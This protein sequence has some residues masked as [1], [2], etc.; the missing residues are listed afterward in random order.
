MLEIQA[1][2]PVAQLPRPFEAEG[3]TLFNSVYG[4]STSKKVKRY[5]IVAAVDG[6]ALNLYNVSVGP[7]AQTRLLKDSSSFQVQS[8]RLITSYPVPP[9]STFPCPPC[10][11]RLKNVGKSPSVRY[12]YCVI[13]RPEAQLQCFSETDGPHGSSAVTTSVFSL[14]DTQSPV[15]FLETIPLPQKSG[16]P[17]SCDI[18]VVHQ[19]GSVR[20]IASDLSTQRWSAKVLDLPNVPASNLTVKA[21]HWM[22]RDQA[23]RS[24]LKNRPDIQID[25]DSN[26]FGL[27]AL[28]ARRTTSSD[29]GK[30]DTVYGLW[31]LAEQRSL[32]ALSQS[33]AHSTTPLVL[34]A[35][36]DTETWRQNEG[37][38]YSFNPVNGALSV[39]S[40]NGLITYNLSTYTP[41][42]AS[43]LSLTSTNGSHP[44]HLT[45]S[46]A[47]GSTPSAATLYDS[48]Y[49]SIRS[50]VGLEQSSSRRKR[51]R[52]GGANGDL[53][54]FIAYFAK[55]SRVIAFRGRALIAFDITDSTAHGTHNGLS[56]DSMLVNAIGR[57]KPSERAQHRQTSK[58]LL[59]KFVTFPKPNSDDWAPRRQELEH[60][61]EKGDV[62]AFEELLAEELC[63]SSDS[64]EFMNY[65]GLRLPPPSEPVDQMR[66]D[67]L[68]SKVFKP[69]SDIN[70]ATDEAIEAGDN[71]KIA[72]RTPR[73]IHWLTLAGQLI[74]K[75]V[76]GA[77]H[78]T[79]SSHVITV[80]P[81]AVV[82]ALIR[83][84]P[85]Y[86][87]IADYLRY[88]PNLPLFEILPVA[89]ILLGDVIA[90]ATG[91][92][93][94]TLLRESDEDHEMTLAEDAI[95][96]EETDNTGSVQTLAL[97]LKLP[98]GNAMAPSLSWKALLVALRRF[99]SY[100]SQDVTAQLRSQLGQSEILSIIQVLRQQLFYSG[101]TSYLP[102]PPTSAQPSPKPCYTDAEGDSITLDITL[103]LLRSCLDAIGPVGFLAYSDNYD[104]FE[105]LIPELQSEISFAFEGMQETSHLQGL[106]REVIR[107]ADSTHVGKDGHAINQF[108][109]DQALLDGE[110]KP[111]TIVTLY[112]QPK[113]DQGDV[114]GGGKLLPLSLQANN[115]V[116]PT[117]VRKGGGQLSKRSKRDIFKLQDRN[118][119][120][121]SF[122][123]LV[124]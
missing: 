65:G 16:T 86:E 68:I 119:G 26:D 64:T 55:L 118:V 120:Q 78:R 95:P 1:P 27:L 35:L 42:V 30:Q 40:K 20:R 112:N 4:V 46:L 23:K 54:Q 77:L 17:N 90:N 115:V 7:V 98:S 110:Q 123:R 111:G 91:S 32:S 104:Y 47:V 113:A 25:R 99:G 31:S 22:S 73:L 57:W 94:Q 56:V 28:I 11:I 9:Q 108:P 70:D 105:R 69:V 5:E 60:L 124:F 10:S 62:T 109:P 44:M 76:E 29:G 15:V 122:D 84:Q 45:P 58:A 18:V 19:N 83:E 24:L 75:E 59:P 48:K 114:E 103:R 85:S 50:T 52:N 21:A 67:Y 6:E 93:P 92:L 82:S 37:A 53:I 66:V 43:K 3:K 88:S 89:K 14:S 36:P 117:K 80:R 33:T 101:H 79:R 116:S 74:G 61:S 13:Q 72:L 49:C 107:Y 39:S 97:G 8:S 51:K 121:Y 41:E 87:M 12:T 34:N 71:L 106:L 2:L 81:G 38:Q 100:S 96:T 63:S 102:T